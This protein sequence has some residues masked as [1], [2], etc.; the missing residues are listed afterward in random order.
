M[1]CLEAQRLISGQLDRDPAEATALEEA[2]DHCRTCQECSGFVRSL[3]ALQKAPLPEPPSD[4]HDRIMARVAE[5]L[6]S[7]ASPAAPA[8]QPAASTVDTRARDSSPQQAD[9]DDEPSME[10]LIESMKDRRNR[11]AILA[12]AGAAALVFLVAGF[13]ALSG[14]R[15][16]FAPKTT[17]NATFDTRMESSADGQSGVAMEP[18]TPP[19]EEK[20]AAPQGTAPNYIVVN[21][22]VFRETGPA[23]GVDKQELTSL[24]STTSSLGGSS[25]AP[26]EVLTRD[27]ASI[28]YVADDGGELIA[29]ERVTRRYSGREYALTSAPT[30]SRYGEWPT[31][32]AGIPTPSNPQGAPEYLAAGT[33]ALGVTVF[34]PAGSDTAVGIAVPPGTAAS[35]PA[36][37]NPGW[38]WWQ[39]VQ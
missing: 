21:G 31:L 1:D 37:A 20:L 24:G 3:V 6:A 11:R 12:W 26:R 13:G 35:D 5:E 36:A 18:P 17:S 32:P 23:G 2:K 28:A 33:D 39:P 29:F 7:K 10:R 30:L 25:I 15:T 38:T 27:N 22:V 8:P 9:L 14:I 4:L 16:I 19:A 34:R